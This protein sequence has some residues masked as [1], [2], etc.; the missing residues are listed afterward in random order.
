MF[1]I[2]IRKNKKCTGNK[3]GRRKKKEY[4]YG[5]KLFFKKKE[6]IR[7]CYNCYTRC[8]VVEA[9]STSNIGSSAVLVGV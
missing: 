5:S 4:V 2:Y 6:V 1:Y 9:D 8:V 7:V 3:K